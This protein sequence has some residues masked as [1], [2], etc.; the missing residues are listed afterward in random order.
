[1]DGLYVV[2]SLNETACYERIEMTNKIV[3][4]SGDGRPRMESLVPGL[5]YRPVLK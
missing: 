3:C 2:Y 4:D 5:V 1:M